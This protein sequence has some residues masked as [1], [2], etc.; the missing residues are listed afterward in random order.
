MLN[1]VTILAKRYILPQTYN[2]KCSVRLSNPFIKEDCL[3]ISNLRS[4]TREY[5]NNSASISIAKNKLINCPQLHSRQLDMHGHFRSREEDLTIRSAKVEN[6]KLHAKFM[7]LRFI[8]PE[9]LTI[10]VLHREYV[11]WMVLAPVTLTLTDDL[12][13]SHTN[14]TRIACRYIPD[15]QI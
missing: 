7:A 10:E 6:P 4:F 12:Q 8:V 1:T 14:L 15:M 9:L 11:F 13:A 2:K 5:G 3:L